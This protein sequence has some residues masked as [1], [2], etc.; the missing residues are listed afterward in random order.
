MSTL[1]I[2]VMLPSRNVVTTQGNRAGAMA[3]IIESAV[4]LERQKFDSVWVGDSLIGRPRPEPLT[5]LASVATVT[6]RIE[7]GTATLLPALRHPLQLSQ[8]AATLDLIANGRL[9]LGIGTGF[10]NDQSR[11]E[12]EAMGLDYHLRAKRCHEVIKAC[13]VLWEGGS[14][15]ESSFWAAPRGDITIEPAPINWSG[16]AIWLGGSRPGACR[17]VGRFYEGWMPT[18]PDPQTFANGWAM[19]LEEAAK[20]NRNT[21]RITGATVLTV[22]IDKSTKKA[23]E[24]LR[25]FIEPY[26]SVPLEQVETVVGCRSGSLDAITDSIAEFQDVGVEHLLI[27]FAYKDQLSAI[28]DW[29][30]ALRTSVSK[31]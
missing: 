5:L 7:L 27:R 14:L 8:Q 16:P 2:G 28:L 30:E 13:K 31:I 24:V 15:P 25:G 11:R 19:I 10:P 4:E 17:S 21:A 6:K 18:A 23:R 9:T 26:Y 22:A 3:S 12:L 20:H 1:K 29:G